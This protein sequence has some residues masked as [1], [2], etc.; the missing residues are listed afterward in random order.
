MENQ[1]VTSDQ[2]NEMLTNLLIGSLI[3][4]RIDLLESLSFGDLPL[5]VFG[6]FEQSISELAA[7][8]QDHARSQRG[9]KTDLDKERE[10]I[11]QIG[12]IREELSMIGRV[13]LEQEQ[14]WWQYIQTAFPNYCQGD[15]FILPERRYPSSAQ[16]DMFEDPPSDSD[17]KWFNSKMEI[18]GK[19]QMQLAKYR[20]Q[21]DILEKDAERVAN[22]ITLQ[23]DLK[24]KHA[25]L[26]EAH[27]TSLMSAAI[28]GF[29][30]VTIIFTP[31]AFL[32]SLFALS[33]NQFQANQH[34]STLES[35]PP[36]YEGSY[37]TKGMGE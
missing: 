18:V 32:A 14:V 8:V 11:E 26:K 10:F 6:I 27:L 23:L 15:R 31:L 22:L 37:I 30:I 34:D 19:P 13:L 24:S 16:D 25:A 12:D 35:G 36:Y 4:Q 29:T 21:I 28:I 7:T 1:I 3:S 2:R 20:K 33:T 17:W 9:F 5:S